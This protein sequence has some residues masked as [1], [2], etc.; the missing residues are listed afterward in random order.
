MNNNIKNTNNIC[1]GWIRR[2]GGAT[3]VT[4]DEQEDYEK[5][6]QLFGM[7]KK[8]K[9]NSNG[10]WIRTNNNKNIKRVPTNEQQ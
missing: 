4:K 8:I 7:N 1:Q 6:Q 10:C 5:Q 2:L 9:M 3:I